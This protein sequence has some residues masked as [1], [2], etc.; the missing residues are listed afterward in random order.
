M[1]WV[2]Q[3]NH[4]VIITWPAMRCAVI[5][6]SSEILCIHVGWSTEHPCILK[7]VSVS[8]AHWGSSL[9]LWPETHDMLLCASIQLR[10]ITIM[11]LYLFFPS[12]VVQ[13]HPCGPPSC[14][15]SV[16]EDRV[17]HRHEWRRPSVHI[18]EY[19]VCVCVSV[20]LWL[21]RSVKKI[22]VFFVCY[23][24]FFPLAVFDFVL[25]LFCLSL[26]CSEY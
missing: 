5:I 2:V 14:C 7:C 15:Y 1:W 6:T 24:S 16:R 9:V 10:N 3:E 12:S 8:D 11:I 17:I 21:M 19:Q 26:M 4:P 22:H 25:Y 13:S 20:C 23:V 18:S